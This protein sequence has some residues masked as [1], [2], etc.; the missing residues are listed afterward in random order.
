MSRPGRKRFVEIWL[1]P[2]VLVVAIAGIAG[3]LIWFQNSWWVDRDR[4]PAADQR[5]SD[6]TTVFTGA[7]VDYASARQVFIIRVGESALP[8]GELGLAD[9]GERTID[10][11]TPVQV[12]VLGEDGALVLDLIDSLTVTT[13]GGAIARVELLPWGSGQYRDH[14][15]LLESRAETIGWTAD[16]IARLQDDLTAAQRAST[17][18]TYAA[19]LVAR[20]TIGAAVS[21]HLS[22][23]LNAAQTI[24]V[25]IVEP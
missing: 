12:R 18:G 2:L 16:D 10:P 13:S 5:A 3:I 7:G 21:A 24:L 22:V 11:S 17:D 25:L 14:L 6:G 20:R 23:D 1:A 9:D 4:P 19:D 8:A 15:A